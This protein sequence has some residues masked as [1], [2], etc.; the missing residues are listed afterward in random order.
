MFFYSLTRLWAHYTFQVQK[1][2]ID[3]FEYFVRKKFDRSNIG[4]WDLLKRINLQHPQFAFIHLHWEHELKNCLF[5]FQIKYEKY[6]S[7]SYIY[8]PVWHQVE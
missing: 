2:K 1:Q 7:Q 3:T 6:F 4:K 5:Q 8:A